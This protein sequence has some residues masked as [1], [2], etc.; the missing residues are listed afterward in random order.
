VLINDLLQTKILKLKRALNPRRD[1][2]GTRSV[3]PY[4]IARASLRSSRAYC[5]FRFSWK[6]YLRDKGHTILCKIYCITR[7]TT[8]QLKAYIRTVTEN[9]YSYAF[10]KEYSQNLIGTWNSGPRL[11]WVVSWYHYNTKYKHTFI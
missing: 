9:I 1:F 7:Y 5:A 4:N 2:L 3:R 10:K 6:H 11:W 8:T